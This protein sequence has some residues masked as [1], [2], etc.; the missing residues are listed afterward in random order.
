[1]T[2]E[3]EPA[4]EEEKSALPGVQQA[5]EAYDVGLGGR[6]GGG[7]GRGADGRDSKW[8]QRSLEGWRPWRQGSRR[9]AGS[10]S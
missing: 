6:G 1:M 9:W 10:H 7:R 2:G 3:T 4:A 5:Q 8:G